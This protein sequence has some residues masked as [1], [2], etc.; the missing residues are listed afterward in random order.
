MALRMPIGIAMLL[1]GIVGFGVLNGLRPALAALGT[2]P[3]S[4]AAVYD[5]AVIPLFVLM[6]NLGVGV[7]DGARPLFRRLC[8]DRPLARR[9]RARHHPRVRRL[10]RRIGLQRRVGRHHGQGVPARDA[11]LQLRS[12]PLDRHHRGRRHARHPDP[13]EHRV[14][15]LRVAHRAVDRTAAAGRHP[16]RPAAHRHLH[17]HGRDLDAFQA[18]IRPARPPRRLAGCG[19]GPCSAPAR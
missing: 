12:P 10:C 9:A 14:R 18:R 2:Y 5:F 19:A 17:D 1:V 3:Y 11:A 6:G 13:A 16:A 7:R 15:H 4:Y 8:V